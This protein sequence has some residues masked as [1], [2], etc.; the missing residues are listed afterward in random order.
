MQSA[1]FRTL[2]TVGCLLSGL[3][4]LYVG[5]DYIPR[6]PALWRWFDGFEVFHALLAQARPT[7]L[8]Q[9]YGGARALLFG[10]NAYEPTGTL[11]HRYVT[12]SYTALSYV[13]THPP[14]A[15]LMVLPFAVLSLGAASAIWAALMIGGLI[16]VV[17]VC[18]A[19][20]Y[21]AVL[22]GPML[23]L[24]PPVAD[25]VNQL[26]LPVLVLTFLAYR[27]RERPLVAGVLV[28]VTSLIKFVPALLIM[29]LLLRRQ[30]SALVG[31]SLTWALSLAAIVVLNVG[32]IQAYLQFGGSETATWIA[33]PGNSAFFIQAAR[34]GVAATA[35][36]A[37]L[38]IGILWS[39]LR[40]QSGDT[41]MRWARWNWL[42]VAVLPIAWS[43]SVLPLAL[44]AMVL[45]H[46]RA[47]LAAG[48]AV[49][50]FGPLIFSER[51]SSPVPGFACIALVGL[52]LTIPQLTHVTG[53][54]SNRPC[55]GQAQPT[56][57]R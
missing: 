11:A 47:M 35:L 23:V 41:G 50:G 45:F 38:A 55:R 30:W 37:A 22:L 51:A 31:F 27:C 21:V 49:L 29:P 46:R 17:R 52:G 57:G 5:L 9:D 8:L 4:G 13:S 28:G 34:Y 15:F 24:L 33:E 3:L 10:G 16:A 42:A 39:D 43:F 7:D 44:S 1:V 32:A 18:G 25:G 12:V 36:A 6:V 56:P 14:T 2:I 19:P 26:A 40:D 54:G 48:V 53:I 20:W